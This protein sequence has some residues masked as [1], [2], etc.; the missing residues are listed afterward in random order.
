MARQA[1]AMTR[2]A[3]GELTETELEILQQYLEILEGN[4]VRITKNL[5]REHFERMKLILERLGGVY[6]TGRKRFAFDLDPAPLLARTVALRQLP[7]KNPLDFYYSTQPVIEALFQMLECDH[8][9]EDLLW[10]YEHYGRPIRVIETGAGLGHL[11]D[12]FRDRYPMASIDVCEIDPYRRAV[13]ESKGYRVVRENAFDYHPS[14][15]SFYDVAF[16]NP[17]FT[18]GGDPFT[19]IKH[20]MHAY[21]MLFENGWSKLVSVVPAQFSRVARYREFYIRVL[22]YGSFDELPQGSFVESGT[23]WDTSVISLRKRKNHFYA[24]WD[25]PDLYDGFPN[26]RVREAWKYISV[27]EQLSS[28]EWRLIDEMLEGRL[29]VYDNGQAARQT[30]E[31]IYAFCQQ[32]TERLLYTYQT[33]LPF[34]PDDLQAMERHILYEYR[35]AYDQYGE[36][37]RLEWERAQERKHSKLQATIAQ[38]AQ[39]IQHLRGQ[40]S[41]CEQRLIRD[42]EALAALERA[43]DQAP[44][45]APAA[46]PPPPGGL[47]LHQQLQGHTNA[48]DS[49]FQ[50]TDA[51]PT[52][53]QQKQPRRRRARYIQRTFF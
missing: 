47:P 20:I 50:L 38:T 16:L 33:Y 30:Q 11:A 10:Q 3:A 24:T 41:L 43:N 37:K 15:D 1:S 9:M 23:T 53:E 26:L 31:R 8:T 49:A 32:V 48:G 21:G 17:A 34:T 29:V 51:A 46:Q 27:D 2:K 7:E 25:E 13:L 35:L 39:R 12:A 44:A 22:E 52:H 42:R 19:F 45:F 40:Y 14:P 5:D 4:L 18:V 28:A 36:M 6:M